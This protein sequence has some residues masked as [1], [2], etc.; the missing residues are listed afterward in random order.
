M[1][2]AYL[3]G[4]GIAALSAA[5]FLIRDGGFAGRDIHIF[6]AQDEVG[7][8]LDA[9]GTP[10]TGY[11]MRGGR[12]FEAQFRCTYDLLSGIPSLDDPS[13]SATQDIL[14]SHEE[15]PWDDAARLVRKGG[16][17]VDGHSVTPPP[18]EPRGLLANPSGRC[19]GP[20]RPVGR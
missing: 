15:S 12:M 20:A 17:I 5:A 3:V 1:A 6:E 8:S 14:D 9:G 4:G 18:R 16:V 2:Q 7:G 19:D 13:K 10:E 11:T